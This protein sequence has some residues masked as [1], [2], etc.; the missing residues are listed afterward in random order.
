[1]AHQ[2]S[3]LDRLPP[4]VIHIILRFLSQAELCA[5][6]R[7]NKVYQTLAEPILYLSLEWTWL[8]RQAPPV[9]AFLRTILRR[10][11]LAA[12]V[13]NVALLGSVFYEP[14]FRG[15]PVP[16]VPTGALCLTEATRTIDLARVPFATGWKQQL[17]AG[18]M[19]AIVA[20]LLSQL[21]NL[22]NLT[23]GPNFTMYTDTL[24][25]LLRWTLC[26]DGSHG[27]STFRYLRE[28]DYEQR[29]HVHR[30]MQGGSTANVLPFFYLPSV[31]AFTVGL[32]NPNLLIWPA[33]LPSS[34]TITSLDI[35]Y[36]REGHI[37]NLLAVTPALKTLRWQFHYSPRSKHAT[38]TSV[39]DLDE[40]SI[41]LSKVR[42][43]LKELSI[44]ARCCPGPGETEL[45]FLNL[46]G[47]LNGLADFCHLHK[48]EIPLPF[49]VTFSPDKG[50]RLQDAVPPQICHLTLTDELL[51]HR[52]ISE[53]LWDTGGNDWDDDALLADI[54]R[55]LSGYKVSHPNLSTLH[56][57][58]KTLEF[59]LES[60]ELQEL[61]RR[62][63][64]TIYISSQA[65][66]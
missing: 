24:G 62:H 16:M 32:D 59:Y 47:I 19:D 46:K 33:T 35:A 28:V 6:C 42:N 34:P 22:T 17:H 36:V 13:H 43:T 51:D 10:P 50:V 54:T 7:V 14:R 9:C 39:I 63:G 23:L 66:G 5:L 41:A 57:L 29:V 58:S 15:K 56:L 8:P 11:D 37:G 40:F 44:S 64:M 45:P 20:L 55:W 52:V 31:R 2:S 48:L 60:E 30:A 1:M 12:H 61:G 3:L 65:R 4:E 21:H 38:S 53:N 26:T 25:M 27:L 18:I 49:L